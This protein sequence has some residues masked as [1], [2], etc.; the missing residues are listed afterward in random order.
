MRG[1]GM[2]DV[3]TVT[4]LY[5]NAL[6]QRHGIFVE[7]RLLQLLRT[8][9]MQAQVVAPVPWFPWRAKTFGR[10]AVYARIPAAEVR[11]GVSIA[12]PRYPVI[13]KM[14]M[15]VAPALMA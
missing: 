6:Q 10:Y 5:P 12:H 1:R 7:Q 4:T 2:L 14:G 9:Q 13:P 15:H 8:G 11:E 3:V